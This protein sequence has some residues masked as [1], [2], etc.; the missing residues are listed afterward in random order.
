MSSSIFWVNFGVYT[1]SLGVNRIFSN[2]F[3]KSS[4]LITFNS[5]LGVSFIT[6]VFCL[7]M[8]SFPIGLGVE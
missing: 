6:H 3:L 8:V 1:G 5:R 4:G 7:A 2:L